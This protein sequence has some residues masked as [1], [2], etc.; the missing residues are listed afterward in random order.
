MKSFDIVLIQ[1]PKLRRRLSFEKVHDSYWNCCFA[2]FLMFSVLEQKRLESEMPDGVSVFAK[3]MKNVHENE[4][5]R[6]LS[7]CIVLHID[8]SF[9]VFFRFIKNFPFT[10]HTPGGF[11]CRGN[12]IKICLI[13]VTTLYT[14]KTCK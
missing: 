9:L 2:H 8:C 5:T 10:N 4:L 3:R 14:H 7:R 12:S 6:L 11:K 13:I 1:L